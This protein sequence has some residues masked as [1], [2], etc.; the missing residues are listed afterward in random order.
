MMS[1][2]GGMSYVDLSYVDLIGYFGGP[3]I[4]V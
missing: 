2:V 1:V 4:L 3:F